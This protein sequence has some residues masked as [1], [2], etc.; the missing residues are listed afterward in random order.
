MDLVASLPIAVQRLEYVFY[1]GAAS[2]DIEFNLYGYD[3]SNRHAG[4]SRDYAGIPDFTD[5][6]ADSKAPTNLHGCLCVGA[7]LR[8]KRT[9]S[10]S[11]PP[12]PGK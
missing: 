8:P 1:T 12:A 2:D 6:L 3:I 10:H 11:R 7:G 9:F 4:G 5:A